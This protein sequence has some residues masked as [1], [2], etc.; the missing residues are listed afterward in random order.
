MYTAASDVTNATNIGE[1]SA[2]I[3]IDLESFPAA[4]KSAIFSG[5]NTNTDD[6]FCIMT[7]DTTAVT[8]TSTSAYGL[9]GN[10]QPVSLPSVFLR[11]DS[12]AMYDAVLICENGVAYTRY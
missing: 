6:P 10:D 12:F 3:A 2:Y 11:I 4:E 7:F 1:G 9:M 5:L 8:S